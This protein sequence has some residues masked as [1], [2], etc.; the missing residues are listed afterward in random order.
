MFRTWVEFSVLKILF[1]ES[2]DNCVRLLVNITEL[3][4]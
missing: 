1:C 2:N 4:L 3:E